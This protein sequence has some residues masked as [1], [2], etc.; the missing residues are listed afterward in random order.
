MKKG[1]AV[2]LL[3]LMGLCL[4]QTF[5]NAVRENGVY[6]AYFFSGEKPRTNA[7]LIANGGGW[8]VEGTRDQILS[9][10]K[11]YIAGYSF[12]TT[13]GNFDTEDFLRKM[14]AE[15][16]YREQTQDILCIY[17][18]SSRLKGGVTVDGEKINLQIVVR[19]GIVTVGTPVI[20]GSF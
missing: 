16:S 3:V 9:L 15:Y 14:K 20:L 12:R 11:S 18:Y 13:S 8:I 10:E 17:G 2:G 19:G 7:Q 6:S 5:M 1:I 4:P